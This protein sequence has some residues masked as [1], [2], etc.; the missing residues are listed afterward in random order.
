MI[1]PILLFYSKYKYVILLT[2]ILTVS[3]ALWSHGYFKGRKDGQIKIVEK[4]IEADKQTKKDSDNVQRK[5]QSLD[6]IELNRALC[7]ANI[8]RSNIGCK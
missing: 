4:I 8:V 3:S 7:D 2:L 6:V 1:G 5:E